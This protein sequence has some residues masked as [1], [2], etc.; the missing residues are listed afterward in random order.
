MTTEPPETREPRL[1]RK[2]PLAKRRA[3]GRPQFASDYPH[4]PA[5]EALLEAF[6]AGNFAY[7]RREAERV[8]SATDDEQVS[9]AA[10]DLKRR[11]S[12]DRASIALLVLG[13]LL[14]LKLFHHYIGL[15]HH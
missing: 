9:A 12:P 6:E 3:T 7:V 2:R 14:L 15:Q 13:V 4:D 5:L 1:K 8:A 11:I 10:R